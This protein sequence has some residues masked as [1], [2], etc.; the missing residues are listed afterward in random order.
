MMKVT[1]GIENVGGSMHSFY[2]I[3]CFESDCSRVL[4]MLGFVLDVISVDFSWAVSRH[5]VSGVR[6][7]QSN[8]ESSKESVC[9]S[10]APS[11]LH[12]VY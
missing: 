9:N 3:L 10:E 2:F 4:F 12:E 8:A 5:N 11:S 7:V 1:R 6:S